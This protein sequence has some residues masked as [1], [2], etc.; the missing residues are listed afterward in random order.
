MGHIPSQGWGKVKRP[1]RSPDV[2]PTDPTQIRHRHKSPIAKLG[3]P[4]S[5]DYKVFDKYLRMPVA[6][7]RVLMQGTPPINYLMSRV[8]DAVDRVNRELWRSKMG[9]AE[10]MAEQV[11]MLK[12]SV[13]GI[14]PLY[15]GN[16]SQPPACASQTLGLFD[17]MLRNP[18]ALTKSGRLLYFHSDMQEMALQAASEVVKAAVVTGS[19][20]MI[21][22]PM[23][24]Q[25]VRSSF[26]RRGDNERVKKTETSAL[27]CLYM[28]GNEYLTG[29]GFTE[30][31]LES[32]VKG[33]QLA[34]KTTI[35]VSHL[36]PVAFHERYKRHPEEDWGAT[37][38]KFTDPK[39]SV[40]VQQLTKELN[41]A[42][43]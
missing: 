9:A 10:S 25:E 7:L 12:L 19:A 36:E 39:L 35:L 26:D 14:P 17:A 31:S 22:F 3:Y 1:K 40:S 41:A 30:S 8:A 16:Q 29:S 24:L 28:V 15:Q 20:Y 27:T 42:R 34:R 43:H 4:E 33:R 23:F 2:N 6:Y 5:G 38:L 32:L 18:E 11:Q 21:N 13:A 37:V